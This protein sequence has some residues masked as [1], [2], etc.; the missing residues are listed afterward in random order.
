MQPA[1]RRRCPRF[2]LA[3]RGVIAVGTVHHTVTILNISM[4]GAQIKTRGAPDVPASALCSLMLGTAGAQLRDFAGGTG[5]RDDGYLVGLAWTIHSVDAQNRLRRLI[6]KNAGI[7]QGRTLPV[8]LSATHQAAF[9]AISVY[10][11]PAAA[12][13]ASASAGYGRHAWPR[14]FA[15]HNS[16]PGSA[17]L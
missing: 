11:G 9:A 12:T 6:W 3:L 14:Q 5:Y 8:V 10:C 2:P 13:G 1:E 7:L 17:R 15:P 4:H 16:Q